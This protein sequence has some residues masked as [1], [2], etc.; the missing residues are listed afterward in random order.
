MAEKKK[1]TPK[2]PAAKASKSTKKAATRISK[3]HKRV[4]VK[5][6]R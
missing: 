2:A 1:V 4:L 5:K 6:V 3:A